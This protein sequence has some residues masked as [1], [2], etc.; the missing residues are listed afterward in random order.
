MSETYYATFAARA[1]GGR[2]RVELGDDARAAWDEGVRLSQEE[3][4]GAVEMWQR[5]LGGDGEDVQ[6]AEFHDE[7]AEDDIDD[8]GS[9]D[10]SWG[11]CE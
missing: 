7:Q 5:G 2:R 9:W 4:D 11:V 8:D 1:G 6:V 10:E 3:A